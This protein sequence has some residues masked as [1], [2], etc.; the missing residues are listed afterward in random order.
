MTVTGNVFDGAGTYNV[1]F[2][3]TDA[4]GSVST[5]TAQFVVAKES[6]ETVYTGDTAVVTAGPNVTTA[7]FRLGAHLNQEADG[8]AGDITLARVTFEL[9]K[10]NNMTDTPDRVVSG[11]AVDAAG[12]TA[13]A[14]VDDMAADTYVVKV[15]VDDANGY[16]VSNP[17]G[18]EV[19]NVTVGTNDQRVNGGGWVADAASANG[20]S[21]FG[22]TVRNEKGKPK[23]NFVFVTRGAD[24]FNYVVKSNAWQGGFLNFAGE[25][26]TSALTCATFRGRCNVQKVDPATGLTVQSWGGFNFT[27]DVRDGDLLDPRQGD[28]FAI[29]VQED[30]GAT[31]RQLGTPSALLTLGG[32]NVHV[33]GK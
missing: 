2:K 25:A 6:A 26:G 33:K 1:G 5:A 18:M 12:D 30:N 7:T 28:A 16:W 3:V 21:N 15:K 23:G 20:K 8:A 27:V 19:V 24:G 14:T 11:V 22:F 9:F 17:V 10:S 4:S 13:P 32:G 29:L 31:W